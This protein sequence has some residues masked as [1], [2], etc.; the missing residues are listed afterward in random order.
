MVFQ[1]TDGRANY[2]GQ[3]RKDGSDRSKMVPD[4]IADLHAISPDRRWLIAIVPSGATIAVPTEGGPPRRICS[5]SCPVAW[6]PDGRFLYVGIAP[7]SRTSAGKT[8]AI[9]VAPGESLPNLP[10]SG[11]RGLDDAAAFPGS[12]IIDAWNISPG[13]DPSIFA[14]VKTTVHRNLYRIPVP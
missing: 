12:R 8:V 7:N 13:S 5:D 1:F 11:I 14:Y 6:A 3:I 9:P 10:P 4:P 2:L